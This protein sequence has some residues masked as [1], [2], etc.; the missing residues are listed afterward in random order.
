LDPKP[1][2]LNGEQTINVYSFNIDTGNYYDPLPELDLYQA[3][4]AWG[5]TSIDNDY[6]CQIMAD[7][8]TNYIKEYSLDSM[9]GYWIV[10]RKKSV[11]IWFTSDGEASVHVWLRRLVLE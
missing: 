11:H 9:K 4:L 6:E 2:G 8:D 10:S 1:I 5:L 3:Y 7:N